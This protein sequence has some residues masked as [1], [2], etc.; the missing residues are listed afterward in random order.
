[1]DGLYPTHINT[2]GVFCPKVVIFTLDAVDLE[3]VRLYYYC[4]FILYYI[5]FS[6][7]IK[8][9]KKKKKKQ[10]KKKKKKKIKRESL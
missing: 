3:R 5:T 1:V 8:K 2:S 6:K 4:P 7:L 10:P 9:K